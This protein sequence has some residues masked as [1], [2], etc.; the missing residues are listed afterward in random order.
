MVGTRLA[1]VAVIT[2][3]IALLALYIASPNVN[4]H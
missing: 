3:A 4:P 1:A 2:L